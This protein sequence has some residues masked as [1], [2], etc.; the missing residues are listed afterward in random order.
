MEGQDA[1]KV[2]EMASEEFQGFI[3]RISA[4]YEAPTM[5]LSVCLLCWGFITYYQKKRH[6]EHSNYIVTPSFFKDEKTFLYLAR[7]H[8]K[9]A[10]CGKKV[11]LFAE[12]CKI[13]ESP[14]MY[15]PPGVLEKKRG[16][17]YNNSGYMNTQSNIV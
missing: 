7:R 2:V 12:T 1:Y 11:A 6:Q 14:Y 4:N 3:T 5:K 17:Y 9:V 8:G 13:T 16:A 15:A 10:P